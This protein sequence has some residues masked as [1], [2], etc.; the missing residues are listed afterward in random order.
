[1]MKLYGVRGWGSGITEG[2]LCIAG[3]DYEFIDIDGFENP[4]PNREL[5]RTV[6]PLLQVPALVLDD[7]TILTETAAITLYLIDAGAALAPASGTTDRAVFY[8]LLIWFVANVYPS[9]T[10]GDHPERW[11]PSAPD[12]L[13]AAT[14]EYREDLFRWLEDQVVEPFVLGSTLSA[15]D[16][17]I[18]AMVTWRPR[19]AWFQANT[20][21]IARIAEK[22]QTYPGLADVMRANGWSDAIS[23][24]PPEN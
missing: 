14:D 21:K 6:N 9:F 5:L 8:R 24:P 11:A 7:G 15:P 20:P 10:Y 17:Y 22:T 2:M 19:R 3:K 18:A 13:L 16:I 4:G 12:E 1:M 23:S